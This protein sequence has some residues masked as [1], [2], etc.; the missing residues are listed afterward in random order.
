MA[1]AWRRFAA[2]K[3][4]EPDAAFW[5]LK[6]V[7]TAGGESASDYLV[8]RAP[9]VAAVLVTG[10]L[11][12]V[13]MV[14]QWRAPRFEVLPYWGAVGLVGVF[15]TMCA[16]VVHVAFGVPYLVSTTVF[17]LALA[18]LFLAWWHRE[19]TV[20]I[21]EVTTSRREL[22]YWGA[23]TATF[24]LGTAAGDLTAATFG[25]GYGVSALLFILAL[26]LVAGSFAATRRAPVTHFWVAY[27]LT[28]PAGASVSDYVGVSRARGGLDHGPGTVALVLGGIFLVGVAVLRRREPRVER[29]PRPVP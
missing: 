22:F 7:T 16:D 5:S 11:F 15:G 6:L 17:A 25:L 10:V 18:V 1:T 14:R 24:A 4:A 2:S 27:V 13:A 21:H 23:V 29:R 8:H 3:V 28:R 19:G 9:P 26:L 20:S 12:L